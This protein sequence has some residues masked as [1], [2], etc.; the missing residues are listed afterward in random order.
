MLLI[1]KGN[2]TRIKN[3]APG[4][5]ILCFTDDAPYSEIIHAIESENL[6]FKKLYNAFEPKAFIDIPEGQTKTLSD[7]L[8]Q[9]KLVAEVIPEVNRKMQIKFFFGTTKKEAEEV[10]KQEGVIMT[11]FYRFACIKVKTPKG[12][13][14]FYIDKF[15]KLPIIKSAELNYV[16]HVDIQ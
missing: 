3:Y 15:R 14:Q 4:E 11:A 9:N 6:T 10:L 2:L 12:K 13:E 16:G 7:K 5:I 1:K 8:K